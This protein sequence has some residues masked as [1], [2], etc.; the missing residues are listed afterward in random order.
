MVPRR[1]SQPSLNVASVQV[2]EAR[3]SYS[4]RPHGLGILLA[5]INLC[6]FM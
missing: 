5:S 2:P 1:F 3:D 4:S 6:V